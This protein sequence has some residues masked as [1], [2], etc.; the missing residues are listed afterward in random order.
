MIAFF[1]LIVIASAADEYIVN[2]QGYAYKV[3]SIG[4]C[5]T[6][7]KHP[8][9]KSSQYVKVDD[10]KY[11]DCDFKE[12]SCKGTGECVDMELSEGEK[13]VKELP[14]R[15]FRKVDDNYSGSCEN[16]DKA[17]D[18]TIIKPGCIKA[19]VSNDKILVKYYSDDKCATEKPEGKQEMECGKCQAGGNESIKYICGSSNI[20]ILALLAFIA[21][22]F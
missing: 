13:Y 11:K 7:A 6:Y 20:M 5:Q 1:A 3:K 18:F 15:V 22:F 12:E 8:E 19:E 4:E 10:K 2:D 9:Y 17:I 16:A 21:F 14:E